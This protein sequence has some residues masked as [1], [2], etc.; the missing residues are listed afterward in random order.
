MIDKNTLIELLDKS[1]TNEQLAAY[2]NCGITTI[3][4]RKKEFGLIGHKTN[5]KPLNTEQHSEVI[6]LA[7]SGKTLEQISKITKISDYR[8]KRYVSKDTYLQIICNGREA[9]TNN[10]IKA[11]IS[12]IF[13]PNKNSA[14]ICGVLQSDGYLSSAGYISL[15]ASDIDFVQNFARFFKTNV[16]TLAK[17]DECH[18]Q[19]FKASFKDIKNIEKFKQVTNIEPRKT[20]INYNIPLW[21]SENDEFMWEF[22]V[23]VFNGDG[24]IYKVK[25][26]DNTFELGISQHSNQADFLK[27]LADFLGWNYYPQHKS[28]VATIQTKKL[29]IVKYFKDNY[30]K[31]N[32]CMYRK[33]N[34]INQIL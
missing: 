34:I 6:S 18:K 7:I 20:Y 17:P 5:C 30:I 23:G 10:K 2:F 15:A 13:I 11:D 25:D 26:R 4:R 1:Y 31:S 24:W 33:L 12:N 16:I 29:D 14:Y 21:I 32:N 8:I 19:M 22:V 9:F 3:K 27:I 28:G